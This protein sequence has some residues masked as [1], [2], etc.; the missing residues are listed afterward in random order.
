MRLLNNARESNSRSYEENQYRYKRSS[1]DDES[2]DQEIKVPAKK[3][4]SIGRGILRR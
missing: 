2:V 4:V 3:S 1:C